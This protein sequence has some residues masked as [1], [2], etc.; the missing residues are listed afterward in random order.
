M[1]FFPEDDSRDAKDKKYAFQDPMHPHYVPKLAA[2]VAAWEAVSEAA[3]SKT[4]KQT[5]AEW[6]R[7]N[8]DQYDL[9]NKKTGELK[10]DVIEQVSS[11]ANW[12]TK[13]GAPKTPAN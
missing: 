10:E 6:L 12:Q 3:P 2:A 8:A 11:V 4:V 5:L 9:R 13:G 7:Q 1:R